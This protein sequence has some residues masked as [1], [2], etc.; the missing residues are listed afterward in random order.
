[1]AAKVYVSNSGIHGRGLFAKRSF[2]PGEIVGRYTGRKTRLSSEDHPH[3]MERYDEDG[4]LLECVMGVGD[5]RFINHNSNPNLEIDEETLEF[6]AV[7]HIG[8]GDELTWYYGD[9]FEAD[10]G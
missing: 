3:V 2:K 9:E 5:F 1:M 7:R 10:R 8:P 6:R 4:Q